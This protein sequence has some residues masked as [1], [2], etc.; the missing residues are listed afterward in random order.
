MA[1]QTPT[2]PSAETKTK[3]RSPNYPAIGLRRALEL[4]QKLWDSDKRQPVLG[5]RAAL[6]MGF[7]A[8]SSAGQLALAAMKKYGLLD[9]E[10]S[11]DQRK[12]KL[13]EFAI[14]L[15]NPSASNR[16]QL[17][18]DAALKPA[19]HLEL[20]GKYGA[21]G[22]SP[23]TIH[24]Y[25]V[26]ERKFTEQAATTLIDQYKDT[27]G[28]AKL[29]DSDKVQDT[30]PG[31]DPPPNVTQNPAA[32]PTK[33]PPY[34]PPKGAYGSAAERQT[35]PPMTANIR[36]LPI[37]LDIGDA[38]IPVGMSD[39][40]FDLLL[41]TLKLWKKKIVRP[42]YQAP[43]PAKE[44]MFPRK[45]IWKNKDHDVPVEIVD[46]A[47]D[48]DGVRYYQSSSGTGIPASELTWEE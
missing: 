2:P 37:P 34:T 40:D 39:S 11:G 20:W 38:P 24:D 35:L 33:V 21:E 23:G 1:E 22:A 27:I 30:Q 9:A 6:N 13:T 41:E 46:I 16:E 4:A 42:A 15:L 26:F 32:D 18:K 36:Y 3:D 45:A 44:M 48:K 12:V 47:G 19:I 14:T 17:L 28:F 5:P 31:Q 25:L 29:A 7:T 10:G 8:K 43:N